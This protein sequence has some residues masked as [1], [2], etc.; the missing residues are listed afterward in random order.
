MIT[1]IYGL[2]CPMDNTVKYVGKANDPNRRLRDHLVD[3]RGV[4]LNKALWIRTL[5]V[6]KLKPSIL[7]LEEVPIDSWEEREKYWIS[8]YRT[9]GGLLNVRNGGEGLSTA[10]KFTFKK[11]VVYEGIT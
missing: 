3:F 6:N 9:I 5:K 8:H 1:Y 7:I 4:E 10:N 2:V 11:K